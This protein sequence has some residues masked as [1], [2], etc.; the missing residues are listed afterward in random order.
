[1]RSGLRVIT[2]HHQSK[3][4]TGCQPAGW[5]PQWA[6]LGE[7]LGISGYSAIWGRLGSGEREGHRSIRWARTNVA[8]A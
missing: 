2:G 6:A 5:A 8:G 4:L 7:M 1:M 3:L